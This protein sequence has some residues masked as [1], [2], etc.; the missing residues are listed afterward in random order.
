MSSSCQNYYALFTLRSLQS[1]T[2][3]LATNSLTYSTETEFIKWIVVVYYVHGIAI[4]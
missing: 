2:I 1:S 4:I 3:Y